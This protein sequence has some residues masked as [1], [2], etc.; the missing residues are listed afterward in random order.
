[1]ARKRSKKSDNVSLA[2]TISVMII[3]LCL[4]IGGNKIYSGYNKST[5]EPTEEPK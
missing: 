5:E 3:T 4:I 1:M 2:S